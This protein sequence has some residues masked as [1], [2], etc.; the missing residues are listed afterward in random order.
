LQ[1]TTISFAISPITESPQYGSLERC[2]RDGVI[3]DGSKKSLWRKR[4]WI[5][6][7]KLSIIGIGGDIAY[8]FAEYREVDKRKKQTYW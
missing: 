2:D 1:N 3:A 4:C 8:C 6:K 7:L 5:P